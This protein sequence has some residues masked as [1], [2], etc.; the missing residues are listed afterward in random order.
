MVSGFRVALSTPLGLLLVSQ[1]PALSKIEDNFLL[2][3]VVS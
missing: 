2:R 3:V 1:A